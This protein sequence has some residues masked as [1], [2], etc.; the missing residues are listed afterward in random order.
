MEYWM[1]AAFVLGSIIQQSK[2]S[3]LLYS[4][5]QAERSDDE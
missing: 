1:T 3:I 2:S 5:I 4:I